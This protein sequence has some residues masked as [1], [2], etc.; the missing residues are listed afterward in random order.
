MLN[1]T[2][3]SPEAL[4]TL[5]HG[6]SVFHEALSHIKEGETRFHVTD[7]TGR[8]PDYD[9]VYTTLLQLNNP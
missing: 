9:L 8:V 3:K 4:I 6:T 1:I 7:E 2:E 5:C